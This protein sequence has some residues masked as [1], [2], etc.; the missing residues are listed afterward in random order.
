MA[1]VP[2]NSAKEVAARYAV[3]RF[4]EKGM[5]LGLG[6]GSTA[7]FAVRALADRI[8]KEN[9]SFRHIIST[10]NDTAKLARSLGID[11]QNDLSPDIGLLDVTIDGADEVDDNLTL[12]KGAGGAAVREKLVAS[13][14]K[15]EVIIVD[16]SKKVTTL[17]FRHPLPV[18]II[19]YAWEITKQR[20]EAIC[21]RPAN[22]RA[23][24]DRSPFIS[25]DHLYTL[26]VTTGPIPN[27]GELQSQ[28]KAIT[29]VVD[30]GLFVGM[31][32]FAVI[33]DDAGN[34]Q[35][36]SN[37]AADSLAPL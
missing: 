18:I 19:P 31:A 25:D 37:P 2:P 4:V 20:V 1:Q 35:E 21:G 11:V 13:R 26:D 22:L 17:G 14:T 33:G 5:A 29:G 7:A 16:P 23:L 32:A 10:S 12:I 3:Q 36:L 30:T 6:S 34:I 8:A 15:R 24:P 9:L 27:P 28:L